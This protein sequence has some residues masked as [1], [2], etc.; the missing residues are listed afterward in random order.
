M[1]DLGPTDCVTRAEDDTHGEQGVI[2]VPTAEEL[3]A[4][5]ER[6]ADAIAGAV[7]VRWDSGRYSWERI[8]DLRRA[9]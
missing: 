8:A 6:M 2:L 7:M 4:G 3:A 5:R 1:N 9:P